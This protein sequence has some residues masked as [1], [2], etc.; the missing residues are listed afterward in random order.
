MS[1]GQSPTL[2][3]VLKNDLCSGCGLCA[4]VS[5]GAIVM[6][7][8][9]DGFNRPEQIAP[10]N[11]VQEEQIAL[12]CPGSV[13]APWEEGVARHPFWG[14]YRSVWTGHSTDEPIRFQGSSGAGIT[15]I[16]LHAMRTG[17]VDAVVHVRP[18]DDDPMQNVVAV[19]E[20]EAEVIGRAGSRYAPSSPLETV[21]ALLASGRRYCFIGKPCDVGALRQL[22]RTDT[23]VATVF[24]LILSFFCGGIPSRRAAASLLKGMD[25]PR[26]QMLTFR[27]RGEGWPGMAKAEL[28][29]GTSRQLS[30]HASWG[31]HLSKDIQFRCKI[32]PDAVGGTA[33]LACAD[34]W[35]GKDGYPDFDER[36][37]RSLVVA[38]TETG[39]RILDA[40]AVAGELAVE[41]L[42]VEEIDRMQPSQARRKRELLARIAAL[43]LIGR[44]VPVMRGLELGRAARRARAKDQARS[45]AGLLYRILKARAK[46]ADRTEYVP[47]V[48]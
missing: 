46:Q 42:A 38:R 17:L 4:G 14:P 30:Y 1:I 45:F 29:D 6:R 7:G 26:D 47:P 28:K 8:V 13:V 37:G 41:P 5:D 12:G 31:G 24:P 43:K 19:S 32:C 15:A 48:A 9:P 3:R 21:N 2:R 36:P 25:V 10:I 27:Y 44:A 18:Q 20:T 35:Y 34:A 23:R 33:D 40:I 16:A 39:Q 22:G 11:A